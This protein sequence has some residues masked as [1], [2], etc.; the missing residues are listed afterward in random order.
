MP[1]PLAQPEAAARAVLEKAPVAP[2]PPGS[3]QEAAG[4]IRGKLQEQ[5]PR[6]AVEAMRQRAPIEQRKID[7]LADQNIG[8][9]RNADGSK[10]RPAGSEVEKRFD[11]AQKYA[12]L[13]KDL[14]EQ[15]YDRLTV[16]QKG[17]ARKFV[18]Q[19]IK[20]WPEGNNLFVGPPPMAATDK[21]AIIEA[22]LKDPELL[23]KARSVFEQ[24]IDSSRAL[25][26]TVSEA[27]TKLDE[28]K[29]IETD[30]KAAIS[31]NNTEKTTVEAELKQFQTTGGIDG[32]KLARLKAIE[33]ALPTLTSDLRTKQNQIADARDTIKDLEYSRRVALNRG[34]DT[35]TIDGEL[36]AKRSESR[37][38]Q[39]E[40][41]DIETQINEKVSL[42]SDRTTFEQKKQQLEEERIQLNEELKTLTQER[43]RVQAEFATAKLSRASQEQDF[44]DSLKGVT[45]EATMQ[46]LEE[47]VAAAEL[48]QRQ[49]L[50]EEKARA[51]DPA[52]KVVL[53]AILTRWDKE[54][55]KESFWSGT[56]YKTVEFKKEKIDIDFGT[57]ISAKDPKPVIRDML[58]A[59]GMSAADADAKLS[60]PEFMNKVQPKVVERLITRKLQTGKITEQ[61][62]R[63]IKE[64]DWGETAVT[65]AIQNKKGLKAMF[66][67]LR[68][69]GAL[70]GGIK[71][72]YKR[73]SGGNILKLLLLIFG[74]ATILPIGAIKLSETLKS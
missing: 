37:T 71:E 64:S 57:M 47:K 40:I 45:S 50:E 65:A 32:P 41:T 9:E 35:T 17:E 16:A 66:D 74:T 3:A 12:K 72:W 34:V 67:E 23:V 30:K 13:S 33:A 55:E 7:E 36:T 8:T 51:V 1:T 58:I 26:D 27:G 5:G 25:Q 53:D 63:V 69:E 6:S 61:E 38:L 39:T 28:A 68:A 52:E 46:Y 31:R 42:E 21:Q 20:A 60:D 54:V 24:T 19:A 56:R 15:G 59:S 14:L 49:L 73:K 10:K 4:K 43:I 44:V 62:G 18:E 11:D 29:K 70:K 48:V 22:V 2:P